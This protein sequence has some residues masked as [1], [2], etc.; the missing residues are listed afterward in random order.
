MF[1]RFPGFPEGANL[2]V[3]LG[4]YEETT[5]L[6]QTDFFL[7][8]I[9]DD[10]GPGLD[11]AVAA[12]ESGPGTD[13]PIDIETTETVLDKDQSSLTAV[14]V[15][16][17][18]G[19]D[20]FYV[21]LMS[22]ATIAMFIFGLMLQRR[23]EYV[24]L[25]AQGLRIRELHALVLAEAAVVVVCGLVAGL[26]V[27]AGVAFLLVHILRALFILDPGVTVPSGR[28]AMLAALVLAAAL[29]SG[30]AATEILRRLKPTEI[31]REE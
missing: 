5:G 18:A 6:Q 16:G 28:L 29:V 24:T 30:L 23:R 8:D 20:S 4:R 11:R 7:A 3:N 25:R 27:G 9:T 14:N 19:L 2:V 31:L 22:A 17:L 13:D 1:D 12:L 26:L 15:D 10:S 21:L